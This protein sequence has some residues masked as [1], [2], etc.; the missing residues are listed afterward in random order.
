[1]ASRTVVVVFDACGLV[2]ALPRVASAG[3]DRSSAELRSGARSIG[4]LWSDLFAVVES[5]LLLARMRRRAGKSQLACYGRDD[6]GCTTRKAKIGTG[7]SDS[8]ASSPR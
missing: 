3:S 8:I 1:V 2:L 4:P 6:C 7:N 5:V